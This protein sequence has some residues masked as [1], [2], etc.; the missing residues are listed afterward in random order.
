[1]YLDTHW[2]S[3]LHTQLHIIYLISQYDDNINPNEHINV[4]ITQV[5]LYIPT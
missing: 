4:Y 1:M 5:G 3:T 2:L